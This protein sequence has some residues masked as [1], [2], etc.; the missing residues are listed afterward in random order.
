MSNGAIAC[1]V[2]PLRPIEAPA[3]ISRVQIFAMS[4]GSSPIR[5]G[6]ISFACAYSPRPPARFE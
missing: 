3:H 4:F 2:I 6:A 5:F 1:A